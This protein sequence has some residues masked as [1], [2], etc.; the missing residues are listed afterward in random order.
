MS[1]DINFDYYFQAKTTDNN[2]QTCTDINIGLK[3]LFEPF[4]EE[5]SQMKADENI[6]IG[7]IEEGYPDL[8]AYHSF[9]NSQALWWWVLLACRQDDSFEGIKK[10]YL[11][12]IFELINIENVKI[13]STYE[14]TTE[15]KTETGNQVGTVVELN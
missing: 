8:V 15:Q 1:S 11:Y 9:F 7:E 12:P 5:K 6:L 4:C 13:D 3:N 10:N 14:T 2:G